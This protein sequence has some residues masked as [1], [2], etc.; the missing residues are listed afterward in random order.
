MIEMSGA[1]RIFL[2]V[3]MLCHCLCMLG[4]MIR[5]VLGPRFTDRVVAVN[6]IGTVAILILCILSYFLEASYLVDVAILYALLNLVAVVVLCRI[7]RVHHMEKRRG[8]G[9]GRT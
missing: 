2:I 3:V 4:G 7:A 9:G 1:L 6:L 5:A 8:K